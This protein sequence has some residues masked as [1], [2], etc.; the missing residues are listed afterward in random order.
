MWHR[1]ALLLNLLLLLLLQH[2]VAFAITPP[3]ASLTIEQQTI[4]P[5][6][7]PDPSLYNTNTTTTTAGDLVTC[8]HPDNPSSIPLRPIRYI[9][10]YT[11][12]ARGLLL[13][14]EVMV[15]KRWA[16]PN[17]PFAYNAGTC[18][19]V[20]SSEED[21]G[22]V[23]W[24]QMAEVAHVASIVTLYCVTN[25][26]PGEAVGGHMPVGPGRVFRVTVLGRKFP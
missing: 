14:D 12:V 16:R 19:I 21:P 20:V 5:A 26:K 9:D 18:M 2:H 25:R 24:F 4:S 22:A 11:D 10:C 8:Y 23:G 15:R 1:L 17:L 6:H 13:G 7:L 3:S